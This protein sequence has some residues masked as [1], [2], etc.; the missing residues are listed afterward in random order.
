MRPLVL[1]WPEDKKAIE[2]ENEYLLGDELLVAPVLKENAK[3]QRVYLPERKWV[4]LFDG[5]SYEGCAEY[6]IVLHGKIPVFYKE[7]H[8]E[9]IDELIKNM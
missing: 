2:Y 8:S 9:I 1:S 3:V 5:N 6:D 7:D 4:N